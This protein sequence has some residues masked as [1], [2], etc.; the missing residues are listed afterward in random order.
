MA[1][2]SQRNSSFI[3]PS[4]MRQQQQQQQQQQNTNPRPDS[5][6]VGNRPM[7]MAESPSSPPPRPSSQQ[8]SNRTSSFFKFTRHKASASTVSS[9]GGAPNTTQ[10][11]RSQ[12][13]GGAPADLNRPDNPGWD[14]QG[15]LTTPNAKELPGG[16][17]GNAAPQNIGNGNAGTPPATHRMSMNGVPAQ[18]PPLHPELRSIVSLTLAHAHKIYYSGPL[19]RRIE[20]AAD[21]HRPGKDEG[22]VNVW[23]QL[24]GTTLSVW[25]MKAVEAASKR[26]EEVPPS[27]VN[28][29]DA[30]SN[31]PLMKMCSG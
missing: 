10:H 20:R 26:G 14:E 25:D 3:S 11:A 4:Q 5:E 9:P 12:T 22:W 19:V 27:Y 6:I 7:S 2:V 28:V 13:I 23:A 24:G 1:S 29:A 31:T 30:V 15:R 8:S 16:Q 17:N 21:G 18:P